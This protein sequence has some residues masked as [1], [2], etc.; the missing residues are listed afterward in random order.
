[1][2]DLRFVFEKVEFDSSSVYTFNET[3]SVSFFQNEGTNEKILKIG[4]SY[5]FYSRLELIKFNLFY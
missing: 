4:F 1:M 5:F 2:H 3:Y